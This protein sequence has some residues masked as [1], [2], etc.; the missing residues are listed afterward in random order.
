MNESIEILKEAL[1]EEGAYADISVGTKYGDYT[2]I[3]DTFIEARRWVD[4]R[5]VVIEGESGDLVAFDYDE[6]KTEMQETE[7]PWQYFGEWEIFP[8][9]AKTKTVTYYEKG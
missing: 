9:V 1:A 7:F 3:A 6:G 5:R 4:T 2:I 8:V